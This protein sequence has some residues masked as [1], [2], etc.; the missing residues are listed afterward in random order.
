MPTSDRVAISVATA[1]MPVRAEREHGR[2][3]YDHRLRD[4]VRQTGDIGI[5]TDLGVPRSTAAGWLC[6][7]SRPVVSMEVLDMAETDLRAE[8]AKLRRRVR[9]LSAVV[10]RLVALLRGSDRGSVRVDVGDRATRARLLRAADRARK[11]LA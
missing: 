11:I 9:V 5:A 4:L 8:V 1:K 6:G 2:Q 3:V 10:G 7:D